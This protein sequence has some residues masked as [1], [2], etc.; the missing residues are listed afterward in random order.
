MQS[1]R[2]YLLSLY[3]VKVLYLKF[4]NETGNWIAG[5]QMILS[6]NEQKFQIDI[7]SKKCEIR[8]II[9]G[10][11][12]S[13]ILRKMQFKVQWHTTTST[14]Q[15]FKKADLVSI[16]RDVEEPLSSYT[17]GEKVKRYSTFL[18]QFGIFLKT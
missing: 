9:E 17:T 13:S 14:L 18:K 1:E 6:K 3:L 12:F 11:I 4:M 2:K 15:W 16:G 5:R 10:K 7:P 8:Q